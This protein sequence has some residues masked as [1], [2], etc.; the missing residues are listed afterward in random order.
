[1]YKVSPWSLQLIK[2]C[3]DPNNLKTKSKD[4]KALCFA[5]EYN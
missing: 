5:L 4:A 3:Y 2:D 1:M